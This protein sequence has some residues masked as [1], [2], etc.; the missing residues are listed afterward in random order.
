M[1]RLVVALP[2]VAFALW[3]L[4]TQAAAGRDTARSF[5]ASTDPASV[6]LYVATTAPGV[7]QTRSMTVY[8]DGRVELV[9]NRLNKIEAEYS[10]HFEPAEIDRLLKIAVDHGLAEWETTSIEERQARALD[11]KPILAL[12][13]PITYVRL[14]LQRYT[15]AGH[16]YD[17]V[18]KKIHFQA[19]GLASMLSPEIP[20]FTGLQLL[21]D[22]LQNMWKKVTGDA[23]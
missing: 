1:K 10:L 5:T 15:N 21:Y 18:E 17:D 3:L 23:R 13:S 8:G 12:D 19:V 7:A 2:L 4:W 14:S 9:Q 20:E 16:H 22:E 6:V 11:G